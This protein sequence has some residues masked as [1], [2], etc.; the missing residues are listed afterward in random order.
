[1]ANRTSS[2]LGVRHAFGDP[3][4]ISP[5]QLVFHKN[6]NR[7]SLRA[8]TTAKQFNHLGLARKLK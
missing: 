7:F 6:A 4:S 8:H 1:V 2:K 3:K 5:A